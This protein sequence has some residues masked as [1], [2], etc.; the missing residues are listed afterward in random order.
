[1]NG[2]VAGGLGIK[3]DTRIVEV[4]VL[5]ELSRDRGEPFTVPF[6]PLPTSAASVA[7]S[8]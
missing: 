2:R 5:S 6:M 7:E 1:M 8:A 4:F 3:T